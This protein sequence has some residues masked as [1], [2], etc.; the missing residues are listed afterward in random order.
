M[1]RA[2]TASRRASFIK[3]NFQTR[4][5]SEGKR[6]LLRQALFY[7]YQG[8]RQN[9]EKPYAIKAETLVAFLLAKNSRSSAK[10]DEQFYANCI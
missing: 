3:N 6:S 10:T 7:G 4:G 2:G 5:N 1:L 9:A 8:L